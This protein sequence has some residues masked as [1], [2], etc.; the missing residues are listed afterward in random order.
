[1]SKVVFDQ[2]PSFT[3]EMSDIDV[4]DVYVFGRMT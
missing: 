3:V 1:V 4:L 2:S